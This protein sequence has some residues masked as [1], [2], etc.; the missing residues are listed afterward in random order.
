M[1]YSCN[2]MLWLKRLPR[3]FQKFDHVYAMAAAGRRHS[4][5]LRDD[6][7][8]VA[9]GWNAHQQCNIP[10][11]PAGVHYVACAAGFRHSVLLRDDGQAVAF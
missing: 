7:Q 4:L 8:A 11:L 6:G 1:T 2:A 5:L 3:L 9:F 10:A